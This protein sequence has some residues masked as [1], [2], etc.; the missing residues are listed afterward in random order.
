[1]KMLDKQIYWIKKK[2]GL[3]KECKSPDLTLVIGIQKVPIAKEK[4]TKRKV[5]K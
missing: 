1:M 3:I 4:K 2:L 5:R